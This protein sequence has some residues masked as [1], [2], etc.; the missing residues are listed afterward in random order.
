MENEN[1]ALAVGYHRKRDAHDALLAHVFAAYRGDAVKWGASDFYD[2][3]RNLIGNA[4]SIR[5]D[6]DTGWQG[7]KK[8][9]LSIRIYREG[10]RLSAEVSQ[11]MDEGHDL[12]SSAHWKVTGKEDVTEQW[13]E[14]HL[15]LMDEIRTEH[16]A[17]R[18]GVTFGMAGLETSLDACHS[19]TETFL[20]TEFN[21]LIEQ[22]KF[23]LNV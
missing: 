6:F 8:E 12:L 23:L 17:S 10:G 7:C 1:L 20:K 2:D 3:F 19:Q 16:T 11:E 14:E 5:R 18:I 13:L 22:V 4:I 15:Y 21:A 9:I